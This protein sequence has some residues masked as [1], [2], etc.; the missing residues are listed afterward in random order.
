MSYRR[1]RIVVT[2]CIALASVASAGIGALQQNRE[3]P[4]PQPAPA[5]HAPATD[6]SAASATL[7][8]LAIKGRA[9]KTGYTRA[10]FSAGWQDAGNCDMRNHILARDLENEVLASETN[11]TVMSGTLND[12]YT[13]KTITFTRG[14]ASSAKIQID[15]VVALSDAWQKG[16][17]QLLAE[18]RY[19]FAN[20]PLNLLAV[21]G[22]TN[23]Q[24]GDGDAATWLPPNKSFRC[25]Y[26][27]RQ[28]AVK[29]KYALWVTQAEHDAMRR[30]LGACPNQALPAVQAAQP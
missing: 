8:K 26:V 23:N 20:D 30:V 25:R 18:T 13:A 22:P 16:A 12:P 28:I 5:A 27:A 1:R 14:A 11:C 19:Q 10:Q 29:H 2:L 15:H 24:K 17:Q 4:P 21:D 6:A 9:P 7:E 3:A